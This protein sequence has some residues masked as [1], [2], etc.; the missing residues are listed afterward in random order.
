M[1]LEQ[2]L[3]MQ[4]TAEELEAMGYLLRSGNSPKI[5][6]FMMRKFAAKSHEN[7]KFLVSTISSLANTVID[8]ADAE[9]CMKQKA[10]ETIEA[11][12]P[13][14]EKEWPYGMFGVLTYMVAQCNFMKMH[15][16]GNECI[17]SRYMRGSPA[18]RMMIPP[19]CRFVNL[20]EK[21]WDDHAWIMLDQ[22]GYGEDCRE[23]VRW[24]QE[25]KELWNDIGVLDV[26]A[27]LVR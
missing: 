23:L 25:N 24:C 12:L 7:F 10:I 14:K 13:Q 1:K 11:V 22:C 2:V 18:N 16:D 20:G 3:E 9:V 5:M 17:A 27:E 26:Q 15:E 4:L 21:A 8:R 19:F 6:F